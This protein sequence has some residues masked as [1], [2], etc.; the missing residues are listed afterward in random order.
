MSWRSL[1]I[2]VVGLDRGVLRGGD[3]CMI[4]WLRGYWGFGGVRVRESEV[5]A[6][7]FVEMWYSEFGYQQ[8]DD[9]DIVRAEWVT[10]ASLKGVATS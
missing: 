6:A 3:W 1:L 7:D 4:G 8:I 9:D 2:A 10:L 5:G